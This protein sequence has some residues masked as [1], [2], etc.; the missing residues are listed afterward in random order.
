MHLNIICLNTL[1]HFWADQTSPVASQ[2]IITIQ[3]RGSK[4]LYFIMNFKVFN[5]SLSASNTQLVQ[6]PN[7]FIIFLIYVH[8]VV[9]KMVF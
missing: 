4:N 2:K 5:L 8:C 7:G 9:C 1:Y 6:I 3:S